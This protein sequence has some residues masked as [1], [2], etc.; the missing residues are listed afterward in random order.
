MLDLAL[1]SVS[2]L[3]I[4]VLLAGMV[5]GTI[6]GVGA[7]VVLWGVETVAPAVERLVGGL[8]R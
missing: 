8:S 4:P 1:L 5:V 3:D 6:I 7:L 2:T